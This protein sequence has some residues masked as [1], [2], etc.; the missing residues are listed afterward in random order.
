MQAPDQ[1]CYKEK[2]EGYIV[3]PL[4]RVTGLRNTEECGIHVLPSCNSMLN[5]AI[6]QAE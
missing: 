1:L 6:L 4:E 5:S 3:N 2:I